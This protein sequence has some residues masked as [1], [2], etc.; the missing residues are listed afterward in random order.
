MFYLPVLTFQTNAMLSKPEDLVVFET[1]SLSFDENATF[2][3]CLQQSIP[4]F[5][6]SICIHLVN[7]QFLGGEDGQWLPSGERS[8]ATT[9][10]P[11]TES[12]SHRASLPWPSSQLDMEWEWG[13]RRSE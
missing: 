10:G 13:C 2:I 3:R 9:G 8:I 11:A 7:K 12:A 4:Q 1:S 5:P 6:K